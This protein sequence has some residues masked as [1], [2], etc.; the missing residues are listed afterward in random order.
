MKGIQGGSFRI[1]LTDEQLVEVRLLC[2]T[3]SHTVGREITPEELLV[4][5]IEDFLEQVRE[6]PKV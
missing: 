6:Q 3:A 2:H 5:I 4:T 1:E